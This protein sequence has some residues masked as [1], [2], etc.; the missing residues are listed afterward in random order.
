MDGHKETI[1]IAVL[2]SSGKLVME[3]ILETKAR[4]GGHTFKM[5]LS[6]RVPYPS[7][8]S[9]GGWFLIE[10]SSL[11]REIDADQFFG[12]RT[13]KTPNPDPSK[14]PKGRAP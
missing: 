7:R 11:V 4:A 1:S 3:T 9:R 14:P 13:E 2:N 6:L 5:R 8:F 12:H 10:S